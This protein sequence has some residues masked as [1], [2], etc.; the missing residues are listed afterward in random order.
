MAKKRKKSKA[1]VQEEKRFGAVRDHEPGTSFPTPEGTC[2]IMDSLP[3]ASGMYPDGPNR[4]R[5]V[6]VENGGE[7]VDC[8][9]AQTLY[10]DQP[11]EKKDRLHVLEERQSAEEIKSICPPMAP[12]GSRRIYTNL[13][14]V[15]RIPKKLLFDAGDLRICCEAAENAPEPRIGMND[16]IARQRS[17]SE[18]QR[19][20]NRISALDAEGLVKR[21]NPFSYKYGARRFDISGYHESA[22]LADLREAEAGRQ[23]VRKSRTGAGSRLASMF[24][25][26]YSDQAGLPKGP[27]E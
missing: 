26:Y 5:F 24:P 23:A 16:G 22:G 12:E 4:H 1:R 11:T 19:L 18:I 7:Y 8:V 3:Y 25:D 20:K 17:V 27:G 21:R 6:V 15:V 13:A 10:C 9:M 14:E 2:F